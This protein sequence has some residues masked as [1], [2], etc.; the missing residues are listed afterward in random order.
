V[1]DRGQRLTLVAE[2]LPPREPAVAVGGGLPDELVDL[3]PAERG[4]GPQLRH[5]L[6][7]HLHEIEQLPAHVFE[8]PA[9]GLPPGL[10]A[11]AAAVGRPL[12]LEDHGGELDV[13][14]D[15]GEEAVEVSRVQRAQ[16]LLRDRAQFAVLLRHGRRGR[17]RPRSS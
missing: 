10:H 3:A 17:Q 8:G 12:H 5:A 11:V 7:V 15:D 16:S 13:L 2:E 1:R 14:G 4:R 6:P 9:D